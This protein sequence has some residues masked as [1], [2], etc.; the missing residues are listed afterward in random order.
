MALSGSTF[1]ISTIEFPADVCHNARTRHDPHPDLAVV[2]SRTI[3]D[4]GITA[5]DAGRDVG[6]ICRALIV[7]RR[8]T[9][10]HC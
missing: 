6:A 10:T 1:G 8:P 2:E 5:L 4:A 3:D 7:L 9:T